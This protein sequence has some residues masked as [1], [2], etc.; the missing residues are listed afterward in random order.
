M[1]DQSINMGWRGIFPL[2]ENHELM[3]GEVELADP[4]VT[5]SENLKPL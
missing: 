5:S 1:V 4:G 2:N 3:R